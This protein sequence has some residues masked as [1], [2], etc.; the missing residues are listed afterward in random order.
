[1][2]YGSLVSKSPEALDGGI[3]SK[4]LTKAPDNELLL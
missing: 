4:S 3:P 1:M 2:G